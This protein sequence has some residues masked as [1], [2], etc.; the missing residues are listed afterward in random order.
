MSYVEKDGK[1]VKAMIKEL[2][3][4]EKRER[5]KYPL[6]YRLRDELTPSQVRMLLDMERGEEIVPQKMSKNESDDLSHLD[7]L[8][9]VQYNDNISESTFRLTIKGRTLLRQHREVSRREKKREQ[10]EA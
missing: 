2:P 1:N 3:S 5:R 6:F 4:W 9:L 7:N 8:K 10:S